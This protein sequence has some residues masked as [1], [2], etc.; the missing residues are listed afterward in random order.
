[1]ENP[2]DDDEKIRKVF[3]LRDLQQAI[4]ILEMALSSLESEFKKEFPVEGLP[5]NDPKKPEFPSPARELR[6]FL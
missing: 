3:I 2:T 6:D 1:M 5:P 4:H